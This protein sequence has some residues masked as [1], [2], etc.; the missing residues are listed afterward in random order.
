MFKE[1][2]RLQLEI[3]LNRWVQRLFPKWYASAACKEIALEPIGILNPPSFLQRNWLDVRQVVDTISQE[4]QADKQWHALYNLL[5]NLIITR[6]ARRNLHAK[7]LSGVLFSE[8]TT[9]Y[10]NFLAYAQHNC[11]AM[12][13]STNDDFDYNL[14]HCFPPSEQ[15]I[16]VGYREWDGRYFWKNTQEPLYLG[17]LFLQNAEGIRRD[18]IIPANIEVGCFKSAVIDDIISHYWVLVLHKSSLEGLKNL[19]DKAGFSIHIINIPQLGS[20][21]RILIADKKSSSLNK[22]IFNLLLH[23]RQSQVTDFFR[24]LQRR[25]KPFK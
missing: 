9:D 17:A 2:S 6:N 22:A 13:I 20:T 5:D 7:N 10:A 16:E 3:M 15:P 11:S 18:I 8:K 24:Y 19:F 25:Y 21:L 12:R 1:E 14:A 23:H 4:C